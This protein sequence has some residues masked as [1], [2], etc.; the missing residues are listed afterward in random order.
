MTAVLH[1]MNDKFIKNLNDILSVNLENERFGVQEF[2]ELAG[3]S[4][5]QLHR[6]LNVLLGKSSSQFIREYRLQKALELLQHNVAT[7]AEIGY[8]VGFGSP[9]YFNTCFHDYYGY[10]PGEA[11]IRNAILD[12]RENEEGLNDFQFGFTHWPE[13]STRKYLTP[14]KVAVIT[15]IGLALMIVMFL[16]YSQN[17]MGENIWG[18]TPKNQEM[19]LAI[20]PFKNLSE[21]VGNQYLADGIM[22]SI[23]GSLNKLSGVKVISST[24]MEQYR[25]SLKTAP[26]IAKELEVSY[27]V[28]A[29]IQQNENK[30]RIIAKLIEAKKDHQLWSATYDRDLKEIFDMQTEIANNIATALNANLSL[31]TTEYKEIVSSEELEIYSLYLKG[32]YFKNHGGSENLNKS[33][34][35][36]EQVIEADPE[37]ALAYA[38]LAGIFLARLD[39]GNPDISIEEEIVKIKE[40]AMMAIALDDTLAEPHSILGTIEGVFEWNWEAAEEKFLLAISLDPKNSMAR[41]E[42][43]R[44]LFVAE[45]F[46]EAWEQIHQAQLLD[47]LSYFV[48]TKSAIYNIQ[49]GNFGKAAVDNKKALEINKDHITTYWINFD[50][51]IGQGYYE[52][53]VKELLFIMGMDPSTKKYVPEIEALYKDNGIKA[54]FE[55]LIAYDLSRN[56]L[57]I[58]FY[59]AQKHAFIGEREKALDLL[60][61]C[62]EMKTPAMVRIKH[63]IYFKNLHAEPRFLA[64]L[65][66]MNLGSYNRA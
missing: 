29:S 60:E 17:L 64:L 33:I 62:L 18:S 13:R 61:K 12:E 37:Y 6:K 23:Q 54:V 9:T 65:K 56:D 27:L 57:H 31:K 63:N 3:L 14:I 30:I 58:L 32:M 48:Y 22:A 47:P 66:K 24:S 52:M 45:R 38:G 49:G 16:F 41:M 7:V 4:R 10:P 35:S 40:L 11:K 15:F 43:A 26:E 39:E 50:L 44:I 20:L 28:E 51:Y 21:D 42:Y 46:E 5:S 59:M 2:A 55:W 8:M 36:F 1:T 34:K 25:G 19:S 53:A